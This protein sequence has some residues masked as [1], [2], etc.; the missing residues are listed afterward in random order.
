MNL[1]ISALVAI[2]LLIVVALWSLLPAPAQAQ[3]TQQA[4]LVGTDAVGKADQG[5]SVSISG[6]GNTAIFGGNGD[7]DGTGAVWVFTRSGG[8]WNQQGPK[9]VG[10]GAIGPYAAH[11]GGSVAISSDG[12]TAILGSA[13]DDN[14]AGAAWVFIRSDGV[15]TQQAKLVGTGAIG[16]NVEQGV[17]V[18]LS[19]DGNTAIVGGPDDN[20]AGGTPQ[21]PVGAAWVFTR[22][23]EM[24]T[25]QAKLVGT[26]AVGSG[27][28]YSVSL[29]ADGNTAIV[30]GFFDN[31]SGAAWVFTRSGGMWSQ[32]G[33]KL[34]GTGATGDALQGIS[35]SLSTDGNTALVGGWGDDNYAGATWVFTRSAGTW[36]Q[37]GA[38]LVGTGAIGPRVFQGYSVSLSA[39]GNTGLV[40]GY[41]DDNRLGAAWVFTRERGAW[42]QQGNKLVGTGVLGA[43]GGAWQGASVSLSGDGSTAIVGGPLDNSDVGNGG[44]GAAWVFAQPPVFAGTP[45][46]ANCHGQSVSSL[47]RKYSGLNSAAAALGFPDVSALQ[48]AILMFCEG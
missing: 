22:S 26:D 17:S 41:G 31:P 11:Q 5:I 38:K 13:T 40:G 47:A 36:S 14:F 44:V 46:K 10:T 12:N 33:P 30:G 42:S 3:F 32:Q 2:A 35:V 48:N 18:A 4:K 9:L 15:W 27:Q 21:S 23:G 28:G 39:D 25:Q 19:S 6:D 7:S 20:P 45:G 16:P 37:Q 29:S 8:V 43:F 24:W 1:R 34:V